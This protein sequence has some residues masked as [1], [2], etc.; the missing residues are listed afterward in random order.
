[1]NTPIEIFYS[2]AH[3]DKT[4]RG[5][6]N[7]HL[8]M[9]V[10]NGLIT[11]W[12]D[13]EISAGSVWDDEIHEH[14]RRAQIILF[15]VSPDFLASDYCW[16]V[17]VQ[18]ALKRHEAGEVRVIPILLESCDWQQTP[19]ATLQILPSNARAVTMW[20]NRNAA[21]TD[22][23]QGIRRVVE[24]LNGTTVS[25]PEKGTEQETQSMGGE[26]GR[27]NMARTPQVINKAFLKKVAKQYHTELKDFQKVVTH[28]TG[29]RGAFLNMLAAMA[30]HCGW[31]LAPEMTMAIKNRNIRPDGVILDEFHIRPGIWEAKGPNVHLEQEIREKIARG[32]PLNNTI[33]E[34]DQRAVLY[35]NNQRM[36][37]EYDLT[38]QTRVMD[39]MRDFFTYVEPDIENFEEA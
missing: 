24:E 17:E 23:A 10:R 14:L 4:L 15:L 8:S 7:T 12:H 9:L 13:Q 25:Q 28:E 6:L 36:P 39:L 31:S 30:K 27:R 33:F 20:D 18:E 32:Y 1:M 3:E 2:Y 16:G 35:Q 21:L 29:V 34:D 11:S 37:G 26:A 19:F 22:I 5:R 38:D